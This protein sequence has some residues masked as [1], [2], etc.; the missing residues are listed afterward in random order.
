MKIRLYLS[1]IIVLFVSCQKLDT[2]LFNAQTDIDAYLWDAYE[3]DREFHIG[4][5]YPVLAGEF[6]SFVVASEFEGESAQ[7][8]A[9]YLGDVNAIPQDT[10][11]VYCHGNTGH[12]DF[13]WERAKL[14]YYAGAVSRYGVLMMDYRGFGLS[15]G[16]VSEPALASDVMASIQWLL[17]RGADPKKLVMYGFSLGSIPAIEICASDAM[18][19][20]RL[21]LEAPIGNI[22]VMVQGSSSLS[23]PASFFTEIES[24]NIERIRQVSEPLLWIHGMADSFLPYDT[25]GQPLFDN[26]PGPEKNRILVEGGEHGDTPAIMGLELYMTEIDAFIR[27]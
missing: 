26:H 21:I 16:T 22:D 25:H 7:I 20:A 8:Q 18:T 9:V 15:G 5:N 19:P 27:G 24:D 14:L 6:T 13:Y 1:I 17:D 4:E 3:G 23:M 12:M 2:N 11:I 10:I